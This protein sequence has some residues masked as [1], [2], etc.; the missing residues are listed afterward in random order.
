[1]SRRAKTLTLTAEERQ[2]LMQV[3]ERGSDWR[4]R[5]RARTVLLL[6]EGRSLDGVAIQQKLHKETVANHRDAWLARQS[7]QVSKLAY[8]AERLVSAVL[9]RQNGVL[10]HCL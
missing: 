7:S 2:H 1:M 6:D 8:F 9:L 4:E 5:R 10:T 3:E